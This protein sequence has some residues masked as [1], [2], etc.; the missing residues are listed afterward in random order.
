M[1]RRWLSLSGSVV[2]VAAAVT[3]C[4]SSGAS[5]S[6]GAAAR[7]GQEKRGQPTPGKAPPPT[8]CERKIVTVEDVSDLFSG[9]VTMKPLEGDP[10][11][12]VFDG[13]NAYTHV[14][15]T[16]RPGLGDVTVNSWINGTVPVPGTS[17]SGI[18]DRAVWQDTLRELIATKHNVLCD[19]GVEG[20][21]GSTADVQ[22]K[23]AALCGR[24]WAA[25]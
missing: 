8:V 10:Q 19:I 15:V 12:C 14:R 22:K 6:S 16:V 11:S 18:G 24:I 7:S 3:A 17:V 4:T 1:P 20:A 13:P 25:Q 5:A 2:I 9:P 21:S 23:F